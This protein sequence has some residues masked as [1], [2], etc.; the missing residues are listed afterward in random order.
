MYK[1]LVLRFLRTFL[2]GAITQALTVTVA[3]GVTNLQEFQTW[4]WILLTSAITGGLVALD[5]AL[6]YQE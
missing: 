6:R 4:S 3:N 2:A 5:K 1:T